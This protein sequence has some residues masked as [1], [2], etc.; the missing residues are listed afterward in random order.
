MNIF[1]IFCFPTLALSAYIDW[2]Q[3]I[4]LNGRGGVQVLSLTSHN[5]IAHILWQTLSS[6]N[7]S[8]VRGEIRYQKYI[9][10]GVLTNPV[11]IATDVRVILESMSVDMSAN[12]RHILVAYASYRNS[13]IYLTESFNGGGTWT[14]PVS[15]SNSAGGRSKMKPSVL[16]E[17]DTGRVYV[18][19]VEVW[20]RWL[21]VREPEA[22]WFNPQVLISNRGLAYGGYLGQSIDEKNWKRYLHLVYHE[23]YMNKRRMLYMKSSNRG[24]DWTKPEVIEPNTDIVLPLSV[25]TDIEGRIYI[26]YHIGNGFKISWSKNHGSNWES[27]LSPGS[28]PLTRHALT[29]C[30]KG[31]KEKLFSLSGK[32][33]YGTGFLRY[34]SVDEKKFKA[35]K[36][37]FPD[38]REIVSA[39]VSCACNENGQYVVVA[40]LQDYLVNK[41]F[42]AYGV[43]TGL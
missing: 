29:L 27:P 40:V 17:K 25:A 23:E 43:T 28:G 12:G 6:T 21:A 13:D 11:T 1:L 31:F 14:R 20:N 30:G 3:M 36:Y 32:L 34:M 10:N 38:L 7:G 9:P 18:Q 24:R 16:L 39:H 5:G 42:V 8:E 2:K 33:P 4:Q 26:Q 15:V 22:W 35:L 41:T 19:Y 37:P